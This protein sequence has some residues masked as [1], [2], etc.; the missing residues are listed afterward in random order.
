MCADTLRSELL[1]TDPRKGAF[2]VQ[3][4]NCATG[5][6][7]GTPIL[8]DAVSSREMTAPS[9]T[10]NATMLRERT[11]LLPTTLPALDD[12]FPPPDPHLAE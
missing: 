10:L 9:C 1:I 2:S 6:F 12:I 11:A 5:S 7:P 3:F 4:K 8:G